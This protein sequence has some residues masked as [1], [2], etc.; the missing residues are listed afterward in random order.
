MRRVTT[1]DQD[2]ANQLRPCR[3]CGEGTRWEDI[4]H[5]QY[6]VSTDLGEIVIC[7]ACA[8]EDRRAD[9]ELEA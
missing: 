3:E 2:I 7:R 4:D 8:D 5:D 9:H 6:D 1:L